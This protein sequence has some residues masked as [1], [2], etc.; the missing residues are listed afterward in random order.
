M[1]TNTAA[2][3]ITATAHLVNSPIR[4]AQDGA[5]GLEDSDILGYVNQAFRDVI[6]RLGER[7]VNT[8]RAESEVDLPAGETI[9]S[10][11]AGTLPTGLV[12]PIRLWERAEGTTNWTPMTMAPDHLPNNAV[13]TS[14]LTFWE[15]RDSSLRFVGSTV[16]E[17]IRI[18]YVASL[19]DL[20]MPGDVV[21]I[22]GLT[23]AVSYL[24]AAMALGGDQY[25]QD[26]GNKAIQSISNF[27]AH[28]KQSRP[29][30][31]RRLR[32]GGFRR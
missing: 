23:N 25:L 14:L 15:Y 7:G 18:H 24:A 27:D 29:F 20:V 9:L 32:S 2:S 30:R 21:S 3:Y 10:D 19:P 28:M 4:M 12:H 16:D 6:T 13:Q 11:A 22:P 17:D 8:L 26:Q 1:S 5:V 31:R